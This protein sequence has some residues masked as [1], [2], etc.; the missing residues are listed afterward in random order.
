MNKKQ[1]LRP[2]VDEIALMAQEEGMDL[3]TDSLT[4]K[5]SYPD[6]PGIEVTF[7]VGGIFSGMDFVGDEQ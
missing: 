4:L 7:T 6:M 1:I 2:I 5:F 3:F